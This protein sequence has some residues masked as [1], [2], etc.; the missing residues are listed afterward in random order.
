[1]ISNNK[2]VGTNIMSINDQKKICKKYNASFCPISPTSMIGVSRNID[3]GVLPINGLR[4]PPVENSNGWFI[5]AGEYS[6][7]EDFF[8]AMHTYH[9]EESHS[10]LRKYLALPPGWRFLCDGTFEDVWFDKSLLVV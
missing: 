4:H 1:M 7:D 8:E 2:F 3:G 9:L 5:W 10:H 6:Q